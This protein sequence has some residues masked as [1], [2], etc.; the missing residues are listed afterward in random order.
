MVR[1]PV[2]TAGV[3]RASLD[4]PLWVDAIANGT[5]V[6]GK[7]FQRRPGCDAPHKIVEFL[8]PAGSAIALQ[9]SGSSGPVVKVT[10]TRSPG[11]MS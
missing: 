3:Y 6:P 9:F 11:G 7:D 8:P 2:E 1:L 5:V 10:V 4:Q